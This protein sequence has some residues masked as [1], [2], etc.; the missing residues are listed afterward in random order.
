MGISGSQNNQSSMEEA[1]EQEEYEERRRW[2]AGKTAVCKLA[3]LLNMKKNEGR[4]SMVSKDLSVK[5]VHLSPG[6][7]QLSPIKKLNYSLSTV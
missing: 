2:T 4:Q 6:G 5:T 7:F 3:L 1:G